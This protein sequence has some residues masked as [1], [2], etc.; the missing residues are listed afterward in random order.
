MNAGDLSLT[1]KKVSRKDSGTY[2]CRVKPDDSKWKSI[3]E[4]IR[5]FHL[6]VPDMIE[7]PVL[8]GQDAILPC[9]SA[10]PSIRVLLWSR[11]DQKPYKTLLCRTVKLDNDEQHE[12]YNNRVELVDK[13]LK[14]GVV[15]LKLKKVS[16]HDTGRYM[17]RVET[18]DQNVIKK[19]LNSDPIGIIYLQVPDEIVKVRTG[20]DVIL[21]C[22]AADPSISIVEWRRPD[23]EP[24]IVLLYRDGHLKTEGQHSSF[25][26]RVELVNRELKNGDMSFTLKNVNINDTGAY[27]C[28]VESDSKSKKRANTNS[29]PIR[30]IYLQVT[31]PADVIVV[32]VYPGDDVILPCQAAERYISTVKWTRPDLEP[33]TVLLSRDGHLKTDDQHPS[34][35]DRVELV[36]RDLKDRDVS[37]ILK[38]VNINDTGTYKC[39]VKT[40]GTVE[41]IIRII[42]LQVREPA[43]LPVVTVHPGQDAILPCQAVEPSISVVEWS[44]DE[45]ILFYSDK[46]TDTIIHNPSYKGRVDL[47]GK[48]LKG[49]DASLILKNVSSTDNG[50]YE[51]RVG[52]A[53]SRRK[54]RSIIDSDPIRTIRLQVTEPDLIE[55]TVHPGD[56]VI[57]PCQAADPSI[58]AV[59]WSRPDLEPEYVLLTIDG[60]LD[61]TYQHPSFKDRVELVDRDLKDR[62]VSLTLKNVS[63]IDNGTYECRVKPDGSRRKKRAN[64]DSE[65]IR[66]IRLQVTED[67]NSSPVGRCNGL[68]AG[69]A[70]VLFLVTIVVGVLKYK[71]H[72]NKRSG[73]PADDDDEAS[74]DKLV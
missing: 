15:S 54:K 27:E 33:D 13:D 41:L 30:I 10:D 42:H 61:P 9:R 17:C 4:P 11:A 50:T 66:T 26:D 5:T 2:K 62:D 71:R 23:L 46:E 32:A 65:P 29:E 44:R 45:C 52:S 31:D 20:Q 67:G 47:S 38:N 59:E 22:Q 14:N 53:D 37:L 21:P 6:Q 73:P 64:I 48:E 60:H 19:R 39:G 58:R 51:C 57:L 74:G 3:L 25:K 70:G 40:G 63:S 34:F 24:D 7:V 28:R 12:S 43:D 56:D 16:R 35:K 1:L 18:G 68:A 49:G 36:D 8:P 55:V 69:V 72:K